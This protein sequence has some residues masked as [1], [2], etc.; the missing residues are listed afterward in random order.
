MPRALLAPLQPLVD[1]DGVTVVLTAVE[2]WTHK[3]VI[4]LQAASSPRRDELDAEHR[5]AFARWTERAEAARAA[6]DEPPWPPPHGGALHMG[7][8]LTLSDDAGTDYVSRGTQGGGTG[9]EWLSRW[10]FAP[11]VP[12][13]ATRLTVTVAGAGSRRHTCDVALP[14][15]G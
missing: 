7:L 5:A 11:G 12:D 4:H 8:P 14:E 10:E 6:G 13:G 15:P 1:V 2:L 9:T 3:V